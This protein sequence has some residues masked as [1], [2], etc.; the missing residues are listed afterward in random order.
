MLCLHVVSRSCA[1]R[2]YVVEPSSS[3]RAT[4]SPPALGLGGR[5]GHSR[6]HLELAGAVGALV[7][8]GATS[9]TDGRPSENTPAWNVTHPRYPTRPKDI[10]LEGPE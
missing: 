3:Q 7:G 1:G 5:R 6:R 2:F 8:E 4:S 9:C 10:N